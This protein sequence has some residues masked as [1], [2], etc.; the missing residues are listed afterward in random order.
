[1]FF[2]TKLRLDPD[3]DVGNVLMGPCCGDLD[4]NCM[5]IPLRRYAS[6]SCMLD[7]PGIVLGLA[8]F[9]EIGWKLITPG[10]WHTFRIEFDRSHQRFHVLDG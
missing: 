6:E 5:L 8:R 2:E 10:S 1:M 7:Q 4:T 9:P 3:Q